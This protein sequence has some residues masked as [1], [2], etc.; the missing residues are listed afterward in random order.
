VPRGSVAHDMYRKRVGLS[1]VIV[2]RLATRAMAD[3]H[4][5]LHDHGASGYRMEQNWLL[6][7]LSLALGGRNALAPLTRRSRTNKTHAHAEFP[8]DVRAN[9]EER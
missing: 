9:R 4:L 5:P 6:S 7:R 3:L 1:S 8:A 2:T